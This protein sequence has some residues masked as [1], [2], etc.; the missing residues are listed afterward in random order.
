MVDDAPTLFR[1]VY[2]VQTLPLEIGLFGGSNTADPSC[3][4]A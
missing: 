3:Y 4:P 1:G 2:D